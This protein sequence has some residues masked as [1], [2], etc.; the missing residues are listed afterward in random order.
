MQP[1]ARLCLAL[2]L[3]AWLVAA[4]PTE[5]RAQ[6]DPRAQE[7]NREGKA[8]FAASRFEDALESFR[9]AHEFDPAP[10]F[11]YNMARCLERLGRYGEAIDMFRRYLREDPGS[12]KK[13]AVEGTVRFLEE[14]AA[15]TT[16]RFTFASRPE[17]AAVYLNDGPEPVG[18]TPL[19]KWL[20]YGTYRVRLRLD[21][22]VE[23]DVTLEVTRG[24]P[25]RLER[26]LLP[27]PG[28]V[29]LRG[30]PDGAR[31]AVDGVT[32]ATT[33]LAQPLDVAPGRRLVRVVKEG[34]QPWEQEVVV[35]SGGATE[36]GVQL[37]P[38]GGP[39][40]GAAAV[41]EGEREERGFEYPWYAWTTTGLTAAG[42]GV[43]VAFIVLGQQKGDEAKTYARGEPGED[44]DR[45]S[46]AKDEASRD[47]IIGSVALGVAGVAAVGTGLALWLHNRDTGES[48]VDAPSVT[49]LPLQ[50][51]TGVSLE[52]E[53]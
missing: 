8:H 42:L 53:F 22:Y 33:P 43:G 19:D 1:V 35:A 52:L 27:L 9:K 39:A 38:E 7:L 26:A 40:G 23:Q 29:L 11:L 36:L 14:R 18:Q 47:L 50:E 31:I 24:G 20:P 41:V 30:V 44:F 28:R 15:D 25:A 2:L 3:G 10:T 5:G 49:V 34:W 16:A 21:G 17:G 4:W 46:S 45:W 32:V 12:A 37:A 13:E 51:G 48:D 6:P